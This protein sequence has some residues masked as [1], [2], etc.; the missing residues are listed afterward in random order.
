[1][2]LLQEECSGCQL[3]WDALL[4]TTGFGNALPCVMAS[5]LGAVTCSP[6]GVL[7]CCGGMEEAV[8]D[9]AGTETLW[10]HWGSVPPKCCSEA[11]DKG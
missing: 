3:G 8:G 7:Q 2:G 11:V 1:M 4:G 10:R 5:G 9:R 6:A